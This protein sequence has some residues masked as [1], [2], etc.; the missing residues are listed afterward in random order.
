[1]TSTRLVLRVLDAG[2]R[3]LGWVEH[4][5]AVRGDGTLRASHDVRAEISTDGRAVTLSVHWPD[6]NTETRI[7][8]DV[9]V[10]AGQ[11]LAL[12]DARGAM[13]TVGDKPGPLPPVTVG[14][15]SIGL[16]AG[17]LGAVSVQ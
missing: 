11:S 1:M 15:R 5:A 7:P 2:G 3:M 9:A 8:I 16:P 13:V 12:F 14:S 17:K 10:I 6:V 4:E